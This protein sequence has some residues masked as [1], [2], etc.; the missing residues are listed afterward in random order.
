MGE[1]AHPASVAVLTGLAS[2]LMASADV[3]A[4]ASCV[5]PHRSRSRLSVRR[6]LLRAATAPSLDDAVPDSIRDSIREHPWRG[7]LE[8]CGDYAHLD[9]HV[10]AGSLPPDLR[11]TLYRN[12]P[13][14]LRLGS[15]LYAH[16]FDG[17]GA[18]T[19]LRLDGSTCA[20]SSRLLQTPRVV[21]QRGETDAWRV[22]GA[23]TQASP[24]WRNLLA[25][26]TNP[27]N[28]SV[29]RWAGKLLALCEGGPP[30]EFDAGT[31][32]TKRQAVP[33]GSPRLLGFGAHC[34]VDPVDGHLYNVGTQLPALDLRVFKLNADGIE[35]ASNV[36]SFG[37]NL[38]FVHDFAISERHVALFIL[39]FTASPKDQ[40]L[41]VLGLQALGGALRWHD[42]TPARCVVLRK[43]D[44]QVVLDCPDVPPFS[45]YHTANAYEHGD[46]LSVQVAKL[47]GPREDLERRFENMY[48]A[49]FGREQYNALHTYTFDLAARQFIG[50]E[51]TLPPT[52]GALPMDFPV[53]HPGHLGRRARYIYSTAHSG[54]CG[55]FDAVQKCDTAT[56][57]ACVRLCPPGEYPSE[58]TFVPRA[59]G[60]EEDAGW[61]LYLSY[62][63]A[64]HTTTLTIVD[65]A[66]FGDAPLCVLQLPRHVPHGFHGWWDPMAA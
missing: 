35:V 63:A 41:S 34:K 9:A 65:A 31:L 6:A 25:L 46:L 7:G 38:A 60:T 27:A 48:A 4:A 15:T 53:V 43:S 32:E 23:W 49:V 47:I 13:G 64:T 37:G 39:P 5:V 12:G 8:P 55:F 16:W 1:G 26:P 66:R 21:A 52:S 28:T 36:V 22:R 3:A 56:G 10:V 50:S 19:S 54:A 20:V 45:S 57:T 33:L 29:V 62:V 42:D 59:G 61:V 51:A 14:R 58:V 2:A 30:L 44:L 24:W 11:G 17:D 40:A 18:V